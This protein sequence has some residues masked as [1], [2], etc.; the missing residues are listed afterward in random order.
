[1]IDSIKNLKLVYKF[2]ALFMVMAL[3]VAATGA[4]GIWKIKA[5]GSR[6]QDMM[7]TRAV[8]EK[9]A[10]LMKVAVQESRVHLLDAAAVL[11][12]NDEFELYR[13]DYEAARD[14][15]R[16]YIDLLLK[17]NAKLGLD[18]AP[19]GSDL[20]QRVKAVQE[21]WA[22]F[23]TVA[24]WLL[25]RKTSLLKGITPGKINETAMIA[26]TDGKLRDLRK[27]AIAAA[28]DNINQAIDDLLVAVG[29]LM[30]ETKNE[31]AAIQLN[32]RIALLS[33]IVSA[34]VLA[35]M[36]GMLAANRMVIQPIT[37]MKTAAE[38]IASGE[39]TYQLPIKGND[40]LASLGN[41]IN[42]MA[43]NLKEMFLKIRNVTDSLSQVTANI[44]SSSR[45]V[46]T[47]ADVQKEA[48][49]ET[50]GA[51][52]E[53]NDSTSAVAG[54][55]RNLS[56]SAVDSS[57]AIMQ[58]KQAIESVAESSNTFNSSTLETA[59]SI[60]EM[61]ANISQITQSLERLSASSEEVAS[62]ISEVN[63]TTKEIES[64]ALESVGLSEKVLTEASEKGM[65]TAH[66]AMEG[67][68]NIRRSV[69][70]LS[71]VIHVLGKRSEDIGKVLTMIDDI[72]GQTNL[73]ALNA[74]ILA[75]QAGEQGKSFAVVA[76]AI[77]GLAEKTSLSVKDIEGLISSVQKDARSSVQMAVDGIQSVEN[78][79]QLVRDVNEALSKIAQSSKIS[80]EMS[81][82]I[83]R[84]TTEESRVI[85]QITV[86]IREMSKQVENISAA[87]QEQGK[88]SKFIIEQTEKMK[89]ISHHMKT[90]IEEQRDGSRHIAGSVED[91]ARQSESIAQATGM[92]KRKSTE[93][94]QSMDRIQ[95]TTG[96]LISSSNEMDVAITALKENAQDLFVELRKFQV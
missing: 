13:G 65:K 33:V 92:Q 19:R 10:V 27:N 28:S 91:V 32:A 45:N 59:S 44:V 49:A 87:L 85:K 22:G 74:A 5:V 75:A 52:E 95:S 1:M 23:E 3:I 2:T 72:A 73:L 76:V 7:K 63:A 16:G 21:R 62:S 50:A 55:A 39:L 71:E 42:I 93:I 86:A 54:S 53:M 43:G 57:A 84:S 48:I 35:I 88:G 20:E 81:K 69:G 83:Q 29:S 40:E 80:T 24:E 51:I 8:Q 78:G 89:E 14:R 70:S 47:V 30:N 56:S 68:E 94:V 34:I 25:A 4:F 37:R 67:I 31:V 41:A 15:F 38:K 12:D 58:T 9:M 18:A 17:G 26:I 61:I 6:V 82:A 90:A 11:N 66:A 77:K 60:A 46:L 64:H 79:L 96:K 36:L